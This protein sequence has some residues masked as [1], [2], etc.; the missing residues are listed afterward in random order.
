MSKGEE[1]V[2][3]SI[4]TGSIVRAVLIVVLF[5]LIYILRDVVLIILAAIVIASAIEPGT[6]WFERRGITRIPSVLLIYVA[7]FLFIVSAFYF[8]VV[9]L[10]NESAQFL[11]SLPEY[12]ESLTETEQSTNLLSSQGIFGGLSKSL[13]LPAV[14][15]G[16]NK[17]LDNLSG[18]FL[19]TV[20]VFFG[21][22]MSFLLI[23]VLSFYLAVQ[24]DG[25]GKFLRV[26]TPVNSENYIVDLWRRSREK[27]GLW[28]QGQLLLAVIVAV[29]VF[30][31]LTML[32][33]ENALLLAFLAGIFEIIPLFGPILSAIP[34]IFIAF[35]D[36]GLSLVLLVIGL[37]IIIQ[38]FENHLLYPLVVKK[39]V[40][41][42]PIISILALVIG[43][44]LAGFLGILL[45]VPL[46]T[47]LIELLSD[48]EKR[49]IDK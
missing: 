23:I 16:V 45:S 24:V 22:V 14:I 5:I 19:S 26:V 21:G 20:D 1:K 12:S 34:A 38:Q 36:G 2:N 43:A 39:V 15:Q 37:Y 9:P 8:L 17:T 32:G 47:A 13:S 48:L 46:A 49:K 4:S 10:F 25:V 18:G 3:L 31:G 41:V 40:G 35:L 28:M 33:V 6:R 44:K 7:A 42:P 29:L 30:L 27:I 11:R